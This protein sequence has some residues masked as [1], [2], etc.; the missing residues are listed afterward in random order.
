MSAKD[1]KLSAE[2][3]TMSTEDATMCAKDASMC[4]KDA[5]HARQ[6]RDKRAKHATMGAK[7]ATVSVRGR[8]PRGFLKSYPHPHEFLRVTPTFGGSAN[9]T[10]T[11][12][13]GIS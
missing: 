12:S 1:A 7:D 3:A 10:Y 9:R 4:A 11:G 13:F 2:D 8:A 6:G 5:I